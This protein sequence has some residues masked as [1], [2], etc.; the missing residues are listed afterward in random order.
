MTNHD[1]MIGRILHG[2]IEIKRR[3]GAGGM[4]YV[5]EGYQEHL[6]R[7]V[8]VKVMTP[9]HAQN[10]IAAEY[11][12]R[13]ARSSSRLRHPH[14]IQIIDFGKE[15]D[16]TLFIAMEFIPG[17]PLSDILEE[18]FPLSTARVIAILDQT[19]DALTEAHGRDVIHRDL[20]PDNLMI[21][22][23]R[24]GKD[25]V[26]VLDFGIAQVKGVEQKAGP[27]T[28]AGALV[29]TPHYM[30]P[31]QARGH[32][33]DGRSD[34]FSMGAILYEM[35]TG[36][37]PFTG[38]SIPEILVAVI[39]DEPPS[40][41]AARPDLTIDPQLESVCLRALKKEPEL[42]YQTAAEF[43][44]AL[45]EI[46]ADAGPTGA[47]AQPAAARYI[48]KR[49]KRE[50]E[51]ALAAAE[52]AP[53]QPAANP[54]PQPADPSSAGAQ[55]TDP[56]STG[57]HS[58]KQ[59]FA[60]TSLA[61]EPAQ[62]RSGP[63]GAP[64]PT[65]AEFARSALNLADFHQ[66]LVGQR[67][68]VSVLIAHQ[69]VH[70][71]IDA[72]ELAEAYVDFDQI[73]HE[74]AQKWSGVVHSRNAG[75]TT[76]I[77]GL[78]TMRSD[79]GARA[80]YASLA[81]RARL[82]P[83]T[84]VHMAFGYSLAQ[85]E[86]FCPSERIQSAA[87]EPLDRGLDAV[88]KAVDGEVLID[89]LDFQAQLDRSFRLG[90]AQANGERA[91]IDVYDVEQAPATATKGV[92]GRDR[93]IARLLAALGQIGR[94]SG[95]VLV[96]SG[97]PGVGK[98]ALVRQLIDLSWQRGYSSLVARRR[99]D[100]HEG[101]RDVQRQWLF[102]L[103]RRG[104]FGPTQ[105][106]AT[107]VAQ[108]LSN[109]YASLLQ[110]VVNDDGVFGYSGTGKSIDREGDVSGAVRAAMRAL[111]RLLSQE[112]PLVLIVDQIDEIDSEMAEFLEGWASFVEGEK[113]LFVAAVRSTPGRAQPSFPEAATLL[114]VEPLEERAANALL[115]VLLP[116]TISAELSA[117]FAQLCAGIPLHI[118]QLAHF[119]SHRPDT[120]LEDANQWLGN[121][122]NVRDIL[123]LRL[124]DQPRPVQNLLALL[125]ALGERAFVQTVY[126]LASPSWEPEQSLQKLHD[127][128]LIE[129]SDEEPPRI[130]FSPLTF[131]HVVYDEMSRKSRE[132][133]HMRVAAYLEEKL[134][135]S[136]GGEL[137]T[138]DTLAL[139][140]HHNASGDLAASL[141]LL[142]R[143]IDQAVERLEYAAAIVLLETALKNCEAL[144][145]IEPARHAMLKLQR[146]RVL[147]AQ[148]RTREAL[149]IS[150]EV[151]RTR[152]LPLALVLENRLEMAML[153]L[154]EEDPQLIEQLL[155]RAIAE[156][157]QAHASATLDANTA[158]W[159]LLRALHLMAN[160]QEKQNRLVQAVE[161]L[162][163]A[164]DTAKEHGI[165]ATNNPWGPALVWEPLNQ[166]GRIRLKMGQYPGAEAL[167]EAALLTSQECD[168]ARGEIAAQGN[169]SA[170]FTVQESYERAG[171]AL[172]QAIKLARK[173]GNIRALAKLQHN[174][175]LLLLRQRHNDVAREAFELSA[176]I[177][178]DLDWREG[179]A[180]NASQLSSLERAAARRY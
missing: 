141:S 173:V 10:P 39:R 169:L 34:L 63:L 64:A 94:N 144:P 99:Q 156:L 132:R 105:L 130:V 20:K 128:G 77:F 8:A 12:I 38:R 89:G 148:G 82:A 123:R 135:Q 154:E 35:L 59:A 9:E 140:H 147:H 106:H 93:E 84:P 98:S 150:T 43:R 53:P 37:H 152:D 125:A 111:G 109:E 134:T 160:V 47:A 122:R 101:L 16:A 97:Q 172:Q 31:E 137:T 40:P 126:E 85:G 175:G 133:V 46:T 107:L 73:F 62:S 2:T 127:E 72:E 136:A 54:A 26:K 86:I 112:K 163:E 161:L 145:H 67:R 48:F 49:A 139:A 177:A 45:H 71:H 58:T 52:P 124:Y 81:L 171:H 18:E 66:D 142:E 32:K 76:M 155:R 88:R 65:P 56:Q 131:R 110:S 174:R 168:D 19:L 61:T 118:E 21:E 87:G 42:R 27:L 1:P 102:D 151:D 157:R 44:R 25:F 153:W 95:A 104:G 78:P 179:I 55:F 158:I 29:G 96:L 75:F 28:Q 115:K 3:I 117:R 17:R 69:R 23:T 15:D 116:R 83:V 167:F 92:T 149:A 143:L 119:V 22:R 108:G 80:T 91:V 50:T 120:T 178:R 5:Y 7:K 30:S 138:E 79:D 180:M 33:S 90:P 165:D 114:E 6:D 41:S 13:E 129:I 159:L 176:Q 103:I 113:I 100:S 162:I 74:I 146:A 60:S 11:F 166:L 14:I 164:I 51:A 68:F 4:G 70:R 24:E 121:I 170:L 36:K 57:P